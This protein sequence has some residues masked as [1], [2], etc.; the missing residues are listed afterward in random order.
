M[1]DATARVCPECGQPAG[2]QAFCAACGRNLSQLTRLPTRAQWEAKGASRAVGAES[3]QEIDPSVSE[4][5]RDQR[6][7]STG[8]ADSGCGAGPPE[9]TLPEVRHQPLHEADA[10]ASKETA[11][12]AKATSLTSA[13][14]SIRNRPLAWSLVALVLIGGVAGIAV[15]ASSG[16][17]AAPG[18]SVSPIRLRNALVGSSGAP[19]RI[20]WTCDTSATCQAADVNLPDFGAWSYTVSWDSDNCFTATANGPNGAGMGP[21][22]DGVP[23]R[24]QGCV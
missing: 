1:G 23:A 14:T 15:A 3:T 19:A 12:G 13:T 21:D 6:D 5:Q 2:A 9:T 11:P 4:W 17:T 7:E 18:A 24:V 22:Q 8:G 10:G 20:S 16:G